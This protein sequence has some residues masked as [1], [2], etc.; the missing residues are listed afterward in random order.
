MLD[1]DGQ[2]QNTFPVCAPSQPRT[3]LQPHNV[4]IPKR[5]SGRA[6]SSGDTSTQVGPV[7]SYLPSITSAGDDSNYEH[8]DEADYADDNEACC[9]RY[10]QIPGLEGACVEGQETRTAWPRRQSLVGCSTR[11]RGEWRFRKEKGSEARRSKWEVASG[12]SVFRARSEERTTL[13][14]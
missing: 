13:M 5:G 10:G 4:D 8:A 6:S 11:R 1:R 7:V 9:T 12:A 2:W 14:P 3:F